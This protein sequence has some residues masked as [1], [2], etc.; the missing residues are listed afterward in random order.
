MLWL[1]IKCSC[2]VTAKS[3][4]PVW[5]FTIFAAS[6]FIHSVSVLLCRVIRNIFTSC[7][8][9][10]GIKKLFVCFFG[11][12]KRLTAAPKTFGREC[13]SRHFFLSST[14]RP[15]QRIK[16]LTNRWEWFIWSWCF[17]KK[18]FNFWSWFWVRL[19]VVL[20]FSASATTAWFCPQRARWLFM[21]PSLQFLKE[22]R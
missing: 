4:A 12:D 6:V 2:P 16:D 15:K 22:S 11:G 3:L 14:T 10:P 5:F 18:L 20:V 7:K 17:K 21:G 1:K 19:S 9:L 8:E 13:S